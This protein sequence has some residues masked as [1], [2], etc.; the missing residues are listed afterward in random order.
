MK[1]DGIVC[2]LDGVLY[3]GPEPVEGAAEKIAELREQGVR[4]VFATNNATATVDTYVE[5]LGS[6]R[7]EATSE[8]VLTSAVVTAEA[9]VERGLHNSTAFLIGLEGIREEL[10]KAGVQIIDGPKGRDADI[11]VVSGDWTFDYDKLRTAT[12]ALR[13]GARF[14][15]TNDD[16]T[17]PA[18]DGLWPGA[19]SLLAALEAASGREAE[20]FGKPYAPMMH[21]AAKRLSGCEHI[22]VVGDQPATDLAGGRLMG[23][24]TVLVLSGVTT[25]DDAVEPAPDLVL[26]SLAD[27]TVT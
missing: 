19:G 7:V 14:L 12:H 17:Y 20:V 3:R 18:P 15:A 24:M 11:V 5:R 2:D 22:A 27:L 21:A 10:T 23:W 13:G 4:L 9:I 1:I 6:F 16:L 8:E 25:K 26:G